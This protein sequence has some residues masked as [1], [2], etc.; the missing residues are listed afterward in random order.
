MGEPP[1][2]GLGVG[3]VVDP[4]ARPAKRRSAARVIV[5][6]GDLTLLTRRFDPG[7]SG[8]T[9]WTTPGGG[10]DPGESPAQA[11]VREI[12]EET[13][14]V[15]ATADLIGPVARRV[16]VHGYTDQIATQSELYF[17]WD[18]GEPFEVRPQFMTSRERVSTGESRW[19]SWAELAATE[20]WIW[21]DVAALWDERRHP[22]RWVIDLGTIE[23]S[24]VAVNPA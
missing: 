2:D 10:I 9:W 24:T 6:A 1:T 23:Q 11:A 14:Q 16:V 15:V 13:G 4:A 22:E 5:V 7:L 18:A 3:P 20:E 17:C 12:A 8:P 21:D 19:W